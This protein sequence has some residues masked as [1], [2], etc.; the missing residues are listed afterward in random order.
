MFKNLLSIKEKQKTFCYC[1]NCNNELVSSNSFVSNND[2]IVT[3]KC[4]NCLTITKWLFD[5]PVPILIKN[6]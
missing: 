3:Y 1:P 5:A 6:K 2:E 4:S